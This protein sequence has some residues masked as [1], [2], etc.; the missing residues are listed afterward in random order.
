MARPDVVCLGETMAQ[1]VPVDG[2]L[3]GALEFRL[4]TAGS[5]S[6]VAQALAQLE[7]AVGWVSRLGTDPIGDR[8]LAAVAASGVDV[9]GVRR[10]PRRTGMFVKDPAPA[11]SSVYY[12]RDGS[13]ASTMSTED[14]DRALSHRPRML[15]LTGI[16]PALSDSCRAAVRHAMTAAPAAGVAV[17]F[18][19]N[20]RPALWRSHPAG[21]AATEL[22]ELA[23][24][25]D[26]VFVG[27]DE[28]AEVWGTESPAEI[29]ALLGQRGELVVKDG[30]L[31]A[32]SFYEG[33]QAQVVPAL[34]VAVVE[35]IGAGDAFAAGWL[36]GRL[37]GLGAQA[38]CRLGHL[39]AARAL[40]SPTDQLGPAP[41]AAS[42]RAWLYAAAVGSSWP[43]KTA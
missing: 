42:E 28:A 18:D 16:T 27:R 10:Q 19:V 24:Q 11:G 37:R 6:N 2:S 29:R 5:E 15:F 33:D 14:V 21:A 32:F 23:A 31:A 8:V 35:P 4:F 22:R 26:V 12:Y 17:C 36:C 43:P 34:P 7:V 41:L 13:A 9:S 39:L 40:G 30:A 20:Y 1:L 25:A 3:S 38:S